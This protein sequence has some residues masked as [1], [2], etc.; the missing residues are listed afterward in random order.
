MVCVT[1]SRYCYSDM[2]T[3]SLTL[4][5]LFPLHYT[6]AKV[7]WVSS[8]VIS[9]RLQKAMRCCWMFSRRPHVKRDSYEE[10]NKQS[11]GF[12]LVFMVYLTCDKVTL[13][14]SVYVFTHSA[15]TD[16]C[17]AI[18]RLSPPGMSLICVF[19]HHHQETWHKLIELDFRGSVFVSINT[20]RL[21]WCW[22]PLPY[23]L[24]CSYGCDKS[25]LKVIMLWRFSLVLSEP[26]WGQV[27]QRKS[28]CQR[29]CLHLLEQRLTFCLMNHGNL[30]GNRCNA[31]CKIAEQLKIINIY[32]LL[33]LRTVLIAQFLINH[34]EAV[35]WS[36]RELEPLKYSMGHKFSRIVQWALRE[37][38]DCK[39]YYRKLCLRTRLAPNTLQPTEN[40][41]DSHCGNI[42][43]RTR[44]VWCDAWQSLISTLR[45]R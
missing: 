29:R 7:N 26:N 17:A 18:S 12:L 28:L 45:I 20:K 41:G 6:C 42:S 39:W 1:K 24:W 3:V 30:K 32:L 19:T 2:K 40:T 16:K 14:S 13:C 4:N 36:C 11:C 25:A 5:I 22:W 44:Q 31:L 43:L 8:K 10:I 37:R 35:K 34:F 23:S 33:S 21:F 38:S 9:M 27:R 15:L